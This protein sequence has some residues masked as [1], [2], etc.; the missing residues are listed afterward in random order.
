MPPADL[1]QILRDSNAFTMLSGH[2]IVISGSAATVN[3]EGGTVNTIAIV[4][5]T[6][7]GDFPLIKLPRCS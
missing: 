3:L 2:D 6:T 4:P 1:F 5:T 7:S